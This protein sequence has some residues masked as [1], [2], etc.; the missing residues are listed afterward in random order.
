MPE[1]TALSRL[2]AALA[3][4]MPLLVAA[5]TPQPPL[6]AAERAQREADRV[7]DVIRF[8]TIRSK[9][10]V[11]AGS[12]PAR[13]PAPPAQ[14]VLPHTFAA[15][16]P[17]AATAPAAEAV[18]GMSAAQ[19]PAAMPQPAPAASVQVD[20]PAGTAPTPEAEAET[21]EPEEAPLRMQNF[22][23]PTLTPALQ[24]TLG[25]GDRHVRVRLT[26][27]ADGTVSRAEAVAGVP[28]RLARPA[29]EAILQWQF[30]PLPQAR[31]AE[32][33]IAFRRD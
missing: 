7:F 17:L 23:A 2:L 30:A 27:E 31:T 19:T 28:R 10:T 16:A 14:R 32:V 5:Q 9:P 12:K 6:T 1:R 24:A 4:T 13:P 33:E 26:V 3:L 15:P 25:A 20:E 21:E 11:E 22:V 18:V 29:T 8:H